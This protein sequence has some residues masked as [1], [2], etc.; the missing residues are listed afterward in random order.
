MIERNELAPKRPARR[1]TP[2]PLVLGVACLA[3]ARVPPC[4]ADTLRSVAAEDRAV[5]AKCITPTGTLLRREAPGRAWQPVAQGETLHQGD[6]LL[7]LPGAALESTNGDVRLSFHA[8]LSG[9]SPF[10]IIETA[11][12][13]HASPDLALDCTVD[14]GRVDLVNRKAQ[15]AARTRL[16]VSKASAE[17]ILTEPGGRVA[18]EV[19]GRWLAGVPFRKAPK[20]GEEPVLS[21]VFIVLQGHVDLRSG[22][23]RLAM[24]APPG[25][26]LFHWDSVTGADLTPERLDRLPAWVTDD[27][28]TQL[29]REKKARL[30]EF[31]RLATTKSVEVALDALVTSEDPN[32]RRLAVLAMGALDDLPRL[33]K[34]LANAKHMDVWDN[35]VLALRHW[36]G[37]G[38]GQDQ[39]LYQGLTKEA[40]FA[41]LEAE[42][43][44]Q[45]LH[46]FGEEAL[47]RPETYEMLL[48]YLEHDRLALRGL[49]HWHLYRL[50]PAGRKISYNPLAPQAERARAVQQW[51]RLIPSGQ[52]PARSATTGK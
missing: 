16:R 5:V 37:R 13:L 36:I 25:P 47:A 10:P 38:P 45:L 41:P 1:R 4:S 8:D 9:T 50:V 40:G 3:G 21:L 49:A 12:V 23:R 6:L 44:L 11:V 15:G 22:G 20:P 48:H 7:G 24:Q 35:G 18:L 17:V 31:R 34:T 27:E 29:A 28:K 30:E 26:A 32:Q 2:W 39:K 14:R 51:H 46:S 19:F 42:A 52:V 43:V 33:G